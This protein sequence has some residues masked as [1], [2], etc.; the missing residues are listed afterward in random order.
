MPENIPSKRIN[1]PTPAEI[2]AMHFNVFIIL[3][4]NY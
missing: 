4:L 3:N 2:Q 1:A